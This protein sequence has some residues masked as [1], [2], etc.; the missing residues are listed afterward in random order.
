MTRTMM[1]SSRGTDQGEE[2]DRTSAGFVKSVIKVLSGSRYLTPDG[3]GKDGPTT[4]R[5][6]EETTDRNLVSGQSPD[7]TTRQESAVKESLESSGERGY[8]AG[9]SSLPISDAEYELRYFGGSEG[10]SSF[11]TKLPR[12]ETTLDVNQKNP[13]DLH[14]ATETKCY[15]K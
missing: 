1:S 11:S 14:R 7:G 12:K 8:E 10:P 5:Y 3:S 6:G 9:F 2:P 15:T 13:L 4:D